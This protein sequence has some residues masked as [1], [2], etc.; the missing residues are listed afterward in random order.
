MED[1]VK[2]LENGTLLLDK[3]C[4]RSYGTDGA[5]EPQDALFP[6]HLTPIQIHDGIKA[7]KL[8][9][10]TFYASRE[11]FLEGSVN[12]ESMDKSVIAFSQVNKSYINAKM[13]SH[14]VYVTLLFIQKK[15]YE[16]LFEMYVF[17]FQILLQGRLSLNR[18]VDGDIVAVE[19]LPED[20]WSAP[21][22][23]VLQDDS[24]EDEAA[25]DTDLENE[26]VSVK[27]ID[28]AD[29]TPTG[30]VVGIIRRKWR[31]YCGIL[32]PS[33]VKEVC[34]SCYFFVKI[35]KKNIHCINYKCFS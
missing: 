33:P 27:V 5:A 14:Q 28:P 21:S 31:Q 29:K 16:F 17:F 7:G 8:L 34:H 25:E 20:Q 32:Q 26:V 18:A 30:K 11:N 19:L 24:V 13:P 15:S 12:S 6:C 1:Y 23:L 9:Q 22:D 3:L 10:G 35:V 2:S 4:K